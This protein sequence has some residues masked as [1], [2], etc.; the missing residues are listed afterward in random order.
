MAFIKL[1]FLVL[2]FYL[3]GRD[4]GVFVVFKVT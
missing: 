1:L 3:E 4:D 2:G